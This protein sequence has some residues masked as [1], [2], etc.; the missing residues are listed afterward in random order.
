MSVRIHA[1]AKETSKTSKEVIEI[2][3]ERG[4]DV[5]SASST[6]DNITAQSLIEEFR[7]ESSVPSGSA[8]PKI[9]ETSSAKEKPKDIP[10]V[11]TKQDL[12][13]EREEKE[14]AQ[15]AEKDALLA[16]QAA[17]QKE[18]ISTVEPTVPEVAE[19]TAGAAPSLPPPPV[20]SAGAPP[21]PPVKPPK[22]ASASPAAS[23]QDESA[24][25]VEGNLIIVKPPIV[26]R[27]FA[28]LIGLKPFQ[29]IS[30][31]MEMGYI[32]LHEPDNRGGCGQ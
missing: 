24:G 29:L 1:I 25:I 20:K 7:Q 11:K 3:V 10:F 28:G 21:P 8:D 32:C 14:K 9:E 16:S 26:V 18:S 22:Q 15:Q 31:L 12:D 4:Y 2:L 30:E 5:K 17:M 27:D 13:R 6:I 23:T 19:K